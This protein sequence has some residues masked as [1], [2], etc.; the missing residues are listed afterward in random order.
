MIKKPT[1]NHDSY[2]HR[3]LADNQVLT[4]DVR[5]L[6]IDC[7]QGMIWVTWPDGNDRVL[8]K[9]QSMT[10]HSGGLICVQAFT[11][12]SII[13]HTGKKGDL[14][15]L[16]RNSGQIRDMIVSYFSIGSQR[17]SSPP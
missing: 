3:Q 8:Q 1:E 5:M 12:G 17:R 13:T 14:H 6:E 9:G 4:F 15:A 7:L 16:S 2:Q 10:V 11:A